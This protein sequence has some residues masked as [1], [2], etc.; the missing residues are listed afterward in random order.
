MMGV[1]NS[2][3]QSIAEVFKTHFTELGGQV[4]ANIKYDAAARSFTAEVQQVAAAKPDAIVLLGYQ[5][6][7]AAIVHDAAQRGLLELPW[8]TGDG[9]RDGTFPGQAL[10]SDPSRLYSWK[11]VGIG[12]ADSVGATQFAAAYKAEYNQEPPS[13]SGQAYDAAWV[14]ILAA[15]LANRKGST[16]KDEIP[17]VTDKAGK[18]CVAHACVALAASGEKVA[19]QGATGAVEFDK[20][21]DPAKAVFA[22]WQFTADGVKT[23]RNV[24]AGD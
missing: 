15:V 8:Y 7:G 23:L 10:P 16:V 24:A 18:S 17:N 6:T 4:V 14:S 21:G 1:N 9:I 13:F 22:I 5:D 20:N 2:Y 3:G 11:G 12:Q 19:Y